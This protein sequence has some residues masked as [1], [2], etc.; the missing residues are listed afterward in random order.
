MQNYCCFFCP[1]KDKNEKKM[2]DVCPTCNRRY[3]YPLDFPPK[4]V[5]SYQ[6][7]KP[8]SR[9]FY[10]ATYIAKTGAFS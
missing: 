10:G 4:E 5:G 9:G 3:S 7:I 6:V 1:L 8:L 2:D